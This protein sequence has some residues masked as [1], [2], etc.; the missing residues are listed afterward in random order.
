MELKVEEIKALEP[1]KFNYEEIKKELQEKVKK[2]KN[3]VYS[4]ED[5]KQAK[6]DKA[7]LN[8]FKKALNDEKIRIKKTWLQPFEG[9]ETKIKELIGIVDVAVENVDAQVKGY[10]QKYK[11]EKKAEIEKYFN[12]NVGDY[13]DLIELDKIFN[14]KWLNKTYKMSD[15]ESEIKTLLTRVATHMQIIDGQVTDETMNKQIK[16]FYFNN[17]EKPEVLT[18]TNVEIMESKKQQEKI[19]ELEKKQEIPKITESIT[20]NIQNV[21]E[22]E[23]NTAKS[24]QSMTKT[25]EKLVQIN[26]SVWVNEEQ[27]KKLKLFFIENEIKF[28]RLVL[29]DGKSKQHAN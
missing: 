12:E 1:I 14:D 10:E 28:E 27:A 9:F 15:I 7:T 26:F 11:D 5:M 18:L 20:N 2:Y 16:R 29:E 23:D 24:T 13:K 6:S 4:E 21:S 3:L 22:N 19:E 8:K 17:I 25:V